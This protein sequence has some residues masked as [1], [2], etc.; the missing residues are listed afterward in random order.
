MK[1]VMFWEY[2]PEDADKLVE[3]TMKQAELAKKEPEK[4]GKTL[5]APHNYGWCKGLT[6]VEA[7]EEQLT[8]TLAFWFPELKMVFKP[9]I[10]NTDLIRNFLELTK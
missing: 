2:C 6:I 9:L 3:K 5:L 4:W 7:D 1:Y 10:S 8:R